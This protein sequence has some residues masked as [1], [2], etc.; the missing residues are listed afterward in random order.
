MP[1]IKLFL[2]IEDTDYIQ[3]ALSMYISYLK[4]GEGADKVKANK[5]ENTFDKVYSQIKWS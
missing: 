3:D 1:T 4:D 2:D 5:V